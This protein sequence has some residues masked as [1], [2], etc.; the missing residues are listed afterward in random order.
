MK[1]GSLSKSV[2]FEDKERMVR[3]T[4]A[5][6]KLQ[7]LDQYSHEDYVQAIE[8]HYEV[9]QRVERGWENY[10]KEHGTP[11]QVSKLMESKGTPE[12]G[13]KLLTMYVG[14]TDRKEEV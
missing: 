4:L 11:E 3:P 1:T 6:W 10:V 2:S 9:H 14:L 12:Y 13:T 8:E 7:E 5:D